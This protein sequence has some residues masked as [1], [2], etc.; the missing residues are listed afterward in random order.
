M[1]LDTLPIGER[2]LIETITTEDSM[3]RRLQDM[4]LIVGTAITCVGKAPAGD[5]I[6]IAVRGAVVA[7]RAEDC[8][9]ITV[10]RI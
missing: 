2:A 3:R 5:P 7:L 6:A 8:H 1:T 9:A 4:G 10:R